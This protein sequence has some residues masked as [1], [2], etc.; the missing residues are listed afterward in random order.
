MIPQD[1]THAVDVSVSV[2]MDGVKVIST[3]GR[4]SPY[5]I[6]SL[7]NF[8]TNLRCVVLCLHYFHGTIHTMGHYLISDNIFI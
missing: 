6:A 5:L 3:E 4:V 1:T 7:H 2:S 8:L